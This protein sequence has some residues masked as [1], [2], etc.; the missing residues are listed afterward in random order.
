[1]K[2]ESWK[3]TFWQTVQQP[4]FAGTLKQASLDGNLAAWTS[5]LTNVVVYVCQ[6][7][8]CHAAGKGHRSSL[9][10]INNH[11]YLSLDVLAFDGATPGWHF[12]VAA[13]ELENSATDTRVEYSLW[14]VL[15]VRVPLRVVFCYRRTADE[16]PGLMRKLDQ[17]VINP[18]GIE[19]RMAIVGEVFVV[20]GCRAEASV[21]P[22]DFFRWWQLDKNRGGFVQS[23]GERG[24][25]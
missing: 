16:A 13:F 19:Q 2:A 1:M 12:P 8:G 14:K 23:R 25:I 5:M 18:I 24:N 20:M 11:E 9:L 10:P 3:A 15:S 22:Y 6:Q 7:L 21:F 4:D 17:A